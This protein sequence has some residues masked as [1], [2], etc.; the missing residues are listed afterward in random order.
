MSKY[1]CD[2]FTIPSSSRIQSWDSQSGNSVKLF[3]KLQTHL[4][5]TS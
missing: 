4:T 3:M 5:K 1:V 2:K